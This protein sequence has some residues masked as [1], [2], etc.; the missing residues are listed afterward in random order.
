[1]YNEYDIFN[2]VSDPFESILN[3]ENPM[4]NPME[5]PDFGN[6]LNVGDWLNIEDPMENPMENPMG[7]FMG[8]PMENPMGNFMGNPMGDASD[9]NEGGWLHEPEGKEMAGMINSPTEDDSYENWKPPHS[10]DMGDA[11]DKNEGGWLHEPEGDED[12]W[13]PPVFQPNDSPDFEMPDFEMPDFE[14]PDFEI[15]SPDAPEL[16]DASEERP[17]MGFYDVGS[18]SAGFRP[19]EIGHNPNR[20]FA[21]QVADKIGRHHPLERALLGR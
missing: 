10:G 9:K 12:L 1:M 7:N 5:K 13:N 15:D 17:N 14:M 16:E 18:A 4:E 8:N 19:G 21:G 20:L 3:P 2:P 11:S 6:W